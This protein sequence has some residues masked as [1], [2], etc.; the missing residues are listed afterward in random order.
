M[1]FR[2]IR[3]I[4][5]R[6]PALSGSFM[7]RA[8]RHKAARKFVLPVTQSLRKCKV[9][10]VHNTNCVV[11][12]SFWNIF[13]KQSRKTKFLDFIPKSESK[14]KVFG[15]FSENC[16]KTQSFWNIFRK[17][18]RLSA[19]SFSCWS[20][21]RFVAVFLRGELVPTCRTKTYQLAEQ[22]LTNLPNENL[23]TCRTKTCQLADFVL[24]KCVFDAI[25]L[26]G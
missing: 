7:S 22:K 3:A 18:Y 25:V 16:I 2:A 26:V 14:R 23:P 21:G 17:V 1:D 20:G 15:I 12:S 8:C 6:F 10:G 9:C 11:S 24:D 4:F 5:D 19:S 13:Q